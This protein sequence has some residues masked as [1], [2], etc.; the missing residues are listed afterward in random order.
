MDF[1][2]STVFK[3]IPEFDGEFKNFTNFLNIVEY[4]CNTLKDDSKPKLLEF[5]IKTKISEKVRA[6]LIGCAT[7]Q[8]FKEFK[9]IFSKIVKSNKTSLNIQSDLLRV[10]QGIRSIVDYSS[11]IESLVSELNNIQIAQQGIEF[12]SVIIKLNDEIGLNAFKVGLNDKLKPI[13][14]A[15]RPAT[16]QEAVSIASEADIPCQESAK[17]MAFNYSKTSNK[18]KTFNSKFCNYCKKRGH[19]I[20]ECFKKKKSDEKRVHILETSGNEED[21]EHQSSGG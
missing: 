12:Q 4:V 1:D 6:R 10:K 17:V 14:Y 18:S 2:F 9:D 15:A 20:K 11:Q 3:I 8:T 5:V 7:P 19:D 13:I 21:P 16:L